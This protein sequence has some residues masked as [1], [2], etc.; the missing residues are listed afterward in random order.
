V[1]PVLA[2]AAGIPWGCY[3]NLSTVSPTFI[4][5]CGGITDLLLLLGAALFMWITVPP[6][7][8]WVLWLFGPHNP[9]FTT[10]KDYVK[11]MEAKGFHFRRKERD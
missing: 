4:P 10:R 11:M 3:Q 5:G 6:I 1:I 2:A 9:P 7:I 8:G